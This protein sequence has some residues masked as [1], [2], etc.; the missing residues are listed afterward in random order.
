MTLQ[1]HDELVFDVHQSELE[2]LKPIIEEKMRTAVDIKCPVEVGM[3]TGA[4]WLDAH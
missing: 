1:V 2:I 4:N 3:G